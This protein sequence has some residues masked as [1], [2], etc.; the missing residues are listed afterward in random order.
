MCLGGQRFSSE[1]KL[2]ISSSSV[3]EYAHVWAGDYF[4]MKFPHCPK[5]AEKKY[6][7]SSSSVIGGAQVWVGNDF[8]VERSRIFPFLLLMEGLMS[9]WAKI[10]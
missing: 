9:G 4:L 8:L 2:I 6:N 7:I 5:D 1:E 10:F 3:N